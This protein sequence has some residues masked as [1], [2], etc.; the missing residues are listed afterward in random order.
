MCGVV[1]EI[2]LQDLL[3]HSTQ[4]LKEGSNDQRPNSWWSKVIQSAE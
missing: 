2:F 3:R 1:E 4:S